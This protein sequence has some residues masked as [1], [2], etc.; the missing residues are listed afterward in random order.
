MN[1]EEILCFYKKQL[2]DNFFPYWAVHE[3]RQ[4]GGILNC[5]NNTGR[6]SDSAGSDSSGRMDGT[7][8]EFYNITFLI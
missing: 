4:W 3:D 1:R 2:E 7:Y 5:L 6:C 8:L